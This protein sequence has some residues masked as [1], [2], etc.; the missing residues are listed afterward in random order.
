MRKTTFYRIEK[1]RRNK[2]NKSSSD[3]PMKPQSIKRFRSL[4]Y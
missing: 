1:D 3:R 4:S 2:L